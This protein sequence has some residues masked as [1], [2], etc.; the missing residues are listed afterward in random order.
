MT[1]LDESLVPKKRRSTR[2]IFIQNFLWKHVETRVFSLSQVLFLLGVRWSRKWQI[3][4]PVEFLKKKSGIL[5]YADD[6]YLSGVS[7][8]VISQP[9]LIHTQIYLGGTPNLLVKHSLHILTIYIY[10]YVFYI[11]K[12]PGHHMFE[13]VLLSPFRFSPWAFAPK[14]PPACHWHHTTLLATLL[15]PKDFV[16]WPQQLSFDQ[17]LGH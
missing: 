16:A 11:R 6:T 17:N 1:K 3:H 12:F 8:K 10:I 5:G 7:G 9:T 15:S 2:K 14:Q 13:S 4:Q